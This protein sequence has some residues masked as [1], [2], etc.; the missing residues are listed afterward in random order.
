MKFSIITVVRNR[1]DTVEKAILSVL[2]QRHPDV[3]YI[4]IDGQSTDG[5]LAILKSY[6]PRVAHLVSEK[7]R[8]LY[9]ALNKGIALATGDM[10]GFLHADDFYPNPEILSQ[11]NAQLEHDHPAA[12]L[13]DIVYVDRHREKIV[14][15]FYSA[16][17]WNPKRFSYGWM[18]PHPG[19]FIPL[20]AYQTWGVFQID[21][22]IA[23]DYELLVRFF[24]THRLS[25]K[26]LP[27]VSVHM[28]Q[29]G[30][31][32]RNLQ[33]VWVLNREIIRACAENGIRTSWLKLALK[34]PLKI[35]EL[36]K[37]PKLQSPTP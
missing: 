31:S 12:V 36:F 11:V 28:R 23:A 6:E 34:F 22:R 25:F 1:V 9:D 2:S 10:V 16:K 37:R 32:T 18:P 15:R 8:G 7:D 17:G 5:T 26:Y 13:T 29:G 27:L 33:S 24:Y 21:Y 14:R 30:T 19:A 4:I 35:L 3:E 20:R